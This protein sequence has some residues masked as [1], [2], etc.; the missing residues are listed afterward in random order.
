MFELEYLPGN[1]PYAVGYGFRLTTSKVPGVVAQSDEIP[2]C[3]ATYTPQLGEGHW[4]VNSVG[5]PE[6]TKR[7]LSDYAKIK[8]AILN[9]NWHG[10]AERKAP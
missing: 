2:G 1:K 3:T 4:S 6:D 7:V 8:G 9:P 5:G 10:E